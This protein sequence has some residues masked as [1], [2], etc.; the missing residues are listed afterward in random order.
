MKILRGFPY[1]R[2]RQPLR[3]KE[4]PGTVA[5][6]YRQ[7]NEDIEKGIGLLKQA[8][9]QGISQIHKSHIDY[10]VANGIK[11]RIALVQ[12]RWQDAANAANIARQKPNLGLADASELVSGFND[13]RPKMYKC[14]AI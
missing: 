12:N 1:I 14:M 9:E 2:N 7:I 6:V 8:E 5:N 4:N 10:Y 11:A 13:L 3:L